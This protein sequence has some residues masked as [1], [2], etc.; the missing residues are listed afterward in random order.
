MPRI[1]PRT[2]HEAL[3]D[4]VARL[5]EL[6]RSDNTVTRDVSRAVRRGLLRKVAPRLYTTDT[7]TPLERFTAQ[8]A[9]EVASLLC[10]GAVISHRSAFEMRP[11]EGT[12]FLT[13]RYERTIRLPGLTLRLIRGGG[14]LPH[15]MSFLDVHR[16]SDA[17]AFLENFK[18]T[19]IRGVS[20]VLPRAELETRL[21]RL[22]QERGED[23]LNALRDHARTLVVALDAQDAFDELDA[24]VGALLRS[25]AAPLSSPTALA[26]ASGGR[27]F[28]ARRIALFE[29]LRDELQNEWGQTTRPA[30]HFLGHALQHLA[31]IDAYFSNFIEG[32]RFEIAEAA[33]IVLGND[34]PRARPEDA[35]DI[36]GTFE[37]LRDESEMRVSASDVAGY[38]AFAAMLTR[39]HA[40]LLVGRPDKR[41]GEFKER[42]NRAGNTH[43]VAPEL[44]EGTFEQGLSLFD[45]L[46]TPFQRAAFMMFMV[47]EVHAF[48]DGNGRLAR[49]MMNA[50]LWAGGEARILIATAYR[51]DYLGTLRRLS[52]DQAP[53]DYVRML[54]RAH[55][56]SS[57]LDFADLSALTR[58][59]EDCNAF[60]DSGRRILRLPKRP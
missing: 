6:F 27:P 12:L 9:L 17:R 15:D 48:D 42:A 47:A 37:L 20:R 57:R 60:D 32:T 26:R 29:V 54:N 43:F 1:A 40:T 59:L 34:F 50:E 39:R 25:R 14:P 8:R 3:Q 56:F 30:P 10:P 41:P 35:H 16:A 11:A 58:T 52:R 45:T 28:D 55:E 33:G 24:V 51:T 7:T 21:E 19:K 5:P 38:E 18:R 53:R 36:R 31:F 4:W 23:D 44:V 22:L 46:T 2:A 13:G 49:A